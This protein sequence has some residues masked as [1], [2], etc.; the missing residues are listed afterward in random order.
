MKDL[1]TTEDTLILDEMLAHEAGCESKHSSMDNLSCSGPI[2]HRFT[3][4]CGTDLLVCASAAS[5][6]VRYLE[7]GERRHCAECMMPIQADWT[8]TPA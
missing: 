7:D 5:R 6:N 4:T 2:T 8:V 3:T 1:L